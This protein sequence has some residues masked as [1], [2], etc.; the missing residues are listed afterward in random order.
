ME[1][2]EV[3]LEILKTLEKSLDDEKFDEQ[4][5]SPETWKITKT[6]RNYILAMMQDEG[7]IKG[8]K[9]T[10]SGRQRAASIVLVKDMEITLKGI[11]YLDENTTTAKII[12]AA[13]LLK[14]TVPMI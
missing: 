6:R 4:S 9:I 10:E 3:I 12:K 7:L 1:T 11:M 8:V 13:K 5:V 2:K 14:D